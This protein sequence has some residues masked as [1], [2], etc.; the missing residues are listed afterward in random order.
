VIAPG[1][2]G[3][4]C[5]WC[6]RP[7]RTRRGGSPKRFCSAAHRMAFW[8]ALRRLGE[9]AIAAGI[10]TVADVRDGDPATCTLHT[11]GASRTPDIEASKPAIATPAAGTGEA[12]ELRLGE[13]TAMQVRE[14]TWGHP[15]HE[16]APE[17]M[18]AATSALLQ[19]ACQALITMPRPRRR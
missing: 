3:G 9:K 1:E 10:L 14:L 13:M 4:I 12:I 2:A 7:F 18:A 16:A 19:Y 5:L 8:S 11:S 17:E 6:E 15:R